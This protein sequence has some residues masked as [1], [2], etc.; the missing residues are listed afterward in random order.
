MADDGLRVRDVMSAEAAT[1]TVGDHLDLASDI[2]NLGR[3]RHMPVMAGERL[4]GI[5]SQRDLFRA[6]ISSVLVLRPAAER[7]W[8]AKIRVEEVMTKPV[9]TAMADWGIGRA[10]QI[11]A[12]R[13]IGCLPVLDGDK[14]VGLLSES[15]CLRLLG[16]MLA[17]NGAAAPGGKEPRR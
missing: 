10:V 11:M 12:D 7:E 2:M 17:G 15:D 6:A 9:L 4:V 5:I 14:L 13:R 3:I 16:R 1:L 8:L